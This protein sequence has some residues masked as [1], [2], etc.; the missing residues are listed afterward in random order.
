M[1]S[2]YKKYIYKKFNNRNIK[3]KLQDSVYIKNKK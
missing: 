3:R 2:I 1:D